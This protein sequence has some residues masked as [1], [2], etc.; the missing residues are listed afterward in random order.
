M[1]QSVFISYAT[2]NQ[3]IAF[4]IGRD[5]ENRGYQVWIDDWAISA[6]DSI[7]QKINQGIHTASWLIVLISPESIASPWVQRELGAGI[8]MELERREVFVIPA[9]IGDCVLPFYL[10]E[11]KYADFTQSYERGFNTLL[12]GL[13]QTNR[14]L[15]PDPVYQYT[16]SDRLDLVAEHN[17]A[18][19]FNANDFSSK[20]LILRPQREINVNGSFLFEAEIELLRGNYDQYHFRNSYGLALLFTERGTL[21]LAG[22]IFHFIIDYNHVACSISNR[23]GTTVLAPPRTIES[24]HTHVLTISRLHG[25]LEC[26]LDQY[27]I[28][29]GTY[30]FPL[31]FAFP[32]LYLGDAKAIQLERF[33]VKN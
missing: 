29:N 19:I 9:L 13:D 30:R 12:E 14:R 23:T 6:G 20:N 8:M 4:R 18:Q 28:F 1:E 5:L 7:L 33:K 31:D 17:E 26:T 11:K 22:E 15:H 16:T 2:R 3:E 10:K 25:M 32:G 27:T 24:K 21:G